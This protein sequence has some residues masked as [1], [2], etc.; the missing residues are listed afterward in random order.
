[1][2]RKNSESETRVRVRR[3]ARRAKITSQWSVLSEVAR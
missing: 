2:K 1:M 3:D